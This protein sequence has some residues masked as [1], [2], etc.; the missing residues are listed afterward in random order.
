MLPS[1]PEL[2]D[3]CVR[4][5]RA[6]DLSAFEALYRAMHAPLLAFAARYT[7]DTAR[8][9]EL[10]QDLFFELW[11][12]R[13]EFNVTGGV[14]AY[15]YAAVRNRALN[16]RRRDA[17]EADWAQDEAYEGVRA[18]HRAPPVA[19]AQLETAEVISRLGKAFAALP[20]RCALIMQM[21]WHG[22]LSYAEI[23]DTLGISIK[24][25]EN[26]L[27]RGLKALRAEFGPD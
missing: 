27:S 17:L 19:D 18:L 5:I 21:R 7:G 11:R 10:L 25:V 12:S 1:M 22:G 8:A 6:G 20:T 13:A 15:L 14:S 16:L 3:D 26:Q 2:P 4:R 24:G 23:A 9:E